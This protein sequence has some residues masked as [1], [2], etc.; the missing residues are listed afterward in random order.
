MNTPYERLSATGKR[1]F[2]SLSVGLIIGL[3]G[4]MSIMF[5]QAF[6]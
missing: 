4:L 3:T 6:A 1:L 5:T 2:W